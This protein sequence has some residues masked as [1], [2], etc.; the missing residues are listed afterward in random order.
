MAEMPP[1]T[2][3]TVGHSNHPFDV[4]LRLLETEGIEVVADVRSSPYS[5]F[6]PQFNHEDLERALR[7]AGLRYLFLGEELGGRPVREEHYDA[8]GHALYGPM[9]EEPSFQAA[10][11][12]LL[13]GAQ[14]HR[15]ALLCSE[16]HPRDCHRRL[17]VGKVLAE[18]GIALRHILPGGS[19]EPELE[20]KLTLADDQATLFGDSAPP[21][22]STQSVSQRRRQR[23]SSAA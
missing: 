12:R 16:A 4:F 13:A 3:W 15:I 7:D 21:W 5:R 17:L 22:R 8:E 9:S 6:A 1:A 20:V 14:T 11:D 18:R 2:I 19:V 23:V 10:I